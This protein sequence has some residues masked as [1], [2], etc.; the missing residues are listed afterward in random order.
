MK[1]IPY[2]IKFNLALC[3]IIGLSVGVTIA[4]IL[5]ILTG[6]FLEICNRDTDSFAINFG[7]SAP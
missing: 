6:K 5:C 7:L 3:F 1:R 2:G 4:V